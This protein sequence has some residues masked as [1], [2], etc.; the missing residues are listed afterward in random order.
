MLVEFRR[1]GERGV[2]CV[3][4]EGGREGGTEGERG[5]RE[6]REGGGGV[7]TR[8][9]RGESRIGHR[10]GGDIAAAIAITTAHTAIDAAISAASGTDT[11]PSTCHPQP[12]P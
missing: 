10:G 5:G 12:H 4:R 3:R 1:E 6:G 7:P 8:P 11:N 9:R 2:E